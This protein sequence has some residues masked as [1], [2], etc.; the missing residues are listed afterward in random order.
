M[1][2]EA[3]SQTQIHALYQLT[4]INSPRLEVNLTHSMIKQ[5]NK[6]KAIC[7]IGTCHKL[8]IHFEPWN[9][10]APYYLT[11][12]ITKAFVIVGVC[13][14]PTNYAHVPAQSL[15]PIQL[16]NPLDCS[17]PG[18]SVHGILQARILEW[19][20][21]SFSRGS[22]RPRDRT[23]LSCISRWVLYHWAIKEASQQTILFIKFSWN[24]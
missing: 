23:R 17:P 22:S 6:I 3:Q 1:Y 24:I 18:S 5:N 2:L 4:R 15:S 10:I 13:Y 16:C 8:I 11:W 20:A 7:F 19:V 14:T 9:Y 21:I 12:G